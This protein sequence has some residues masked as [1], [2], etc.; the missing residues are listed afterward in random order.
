MPINWA[1]VTEYVNRYKEYHASQI[2]NVGL[3]VLCNL[4]FIFRQNQNTLVVL[5][6][7]LW[8]ISLG[9]AIAVHALAL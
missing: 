8:A 9:G 4:I 5:S 1:L 7:V 3:V 6:T 2:G